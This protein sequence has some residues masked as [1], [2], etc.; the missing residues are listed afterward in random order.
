MQTWDCHTSPISD[1]I[2]SI[3]L[4]SETGIPMKRFSGIS[5]PVACSTGGQC[6][7]CPWTDCQMHL[8]GELHL[9]PVVVFPESVIP[10]HSIQ[11]ALP[12]T[13]CQRPFLVMY[14]VTFLQFI[15]ATMSTSSSN[16]SVVQFAVVALPLMDSRG[17]LSTSALC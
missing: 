13:T 1:A 3:L 10:S 14:P 4:H 16:Y 11:F 9:L 2:S 12:S 15:Q 6:P 8:P 7:N 5:N 17:N